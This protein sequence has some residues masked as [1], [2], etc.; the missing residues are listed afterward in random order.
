MTA[1][2][3]RPWLAPIKDLVLA[4]LFVASADRIRELSCGK[5]KKPD[6]YNEK[7]GLPENAGLMCAKIFGPIKDYEC[8]CGKYKALQDRGAVCEKCGV[9][10]ISSSRRTTRIGHVELAMPV[11]HP[12]L[13][14]LARTLEDPSPLMMHVVPIM[15][16]ALRPGADDDI[17]DLY[18]RIINRNNRLRR[19]E[20]LNAPEDITT[21]EKEMLKSAVEQ[22]FDNEHTERACL[23]ADEQPLRSLG[24]MTIAALQASFYADRTHL[25]WMGFVPG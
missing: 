14:P 9:E 8:L 6:L 21:R 18:R 10:V 20:E 12:W 3:V 22:L 23:G 17:N 15:P 19:L 11:L 25:L 24:A 2:D 16:P 4:P 7:T 5:V 13:A 1:I